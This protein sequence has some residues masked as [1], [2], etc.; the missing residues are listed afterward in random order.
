MGARSGA[1]AAR[2]GAWSESTIFLTG[3]TSTRLAANASGERLYAWMVGS[4]IYASALPNA[5]GG[6]VLQPSAA[7]TPRIAIAASGHA[8]TVF[9]LTETSGVRNT[10]WASSYE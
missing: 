10:I 6:T 7:S 2:R 8:V 5:G 9:T 1:I 4:A 3:V